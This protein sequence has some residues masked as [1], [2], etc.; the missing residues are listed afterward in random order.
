MEKFRRYTQIDVSLLGDHYPIHLGYNALKDPFFLRD[1]LSTSQVL[2]V[3]NTTLAPMY[4]KYLE[5]AFADRQC[6]VVVLPDGELHKNQQSLMCI[7]D[8][9]I[10]NHHHRDTTLIALGGGVIGDITGFAAST[11]QRGVHFIQIATSLLAQID[12]SVGG[13]TAINHPQGKNMIGS[14]YQP[15]SVIIDLDTLSTLPAREFRSGLAEIL[16]YGLLVGGDFYQRL[17][18]LLAKGL[19]ASSPEL[20]ELIADCCRIKA[21]YVAIDEKEMGT[22]AL[23]NL[24]HTFAHALETYTSYQQYLHGEAV[25]IGLY[26]ASLLS[27]KMGLLA[28]SV[29][30]EVRLMIKYAG[31]PYQIPKSVDLKVLRNLMA[32]D[33]KI[34][35]NSLRFVLLRN[36]GDCFLETGINENCLLN[37]LISVVEG[38]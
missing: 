30:E 7:Y 19:T 32:A 34:K 33:K 17:T 35:D 36:P 13:K 15:K 16:K 21:N 37:T 25:A 1:L 29:V 10:T 26:C 20:P 11:Y 31:L 2:I 18:Y 22:R 5:A 8:S 12:A 4:L 24:G 6:N 38:E 9:L 27:H 3:T 14:F 28:L 23:L